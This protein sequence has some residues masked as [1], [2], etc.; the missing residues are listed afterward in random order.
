MKIFTG[1]DTMVIHTGHQPFGIV[2]DAFRISRRNIGPRETCFIFLEVDIHRGLAVP[3][4]GGIL[5]AVIPPVGRIIQVDGIFDDGL[6]L[7]IIIGS[8]CQD[9]LPGGLYPSV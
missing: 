1:P 7:V 8:I 6:Y 5:F 2:K 3:G 9:T 4:H